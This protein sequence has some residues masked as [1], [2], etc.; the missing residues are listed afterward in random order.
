MLKNEITNPK[1]PKTS[2]KKETK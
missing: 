1:S 2:R